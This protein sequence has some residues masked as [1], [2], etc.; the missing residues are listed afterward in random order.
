MDSDSKNEKQEL[1]QEQND[2]E[3]QSGEMGDFIS[4]GRNV[5]KPNGIRCSPIDFNQVN[6]LLIWCE[7]GIILPCSIFLWVVFLLF[8]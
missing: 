5:S 3:P 2:G 4:N 6:R 1:T 7:F 8:R